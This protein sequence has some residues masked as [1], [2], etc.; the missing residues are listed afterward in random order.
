MTLHTI[1]KGSI[2][3]QRDLF[4]LN[5][6]ATSYSPLMSAYRHAD[7]GV[8]VGFDT[9]ML[10]GQSIDDQS[11]PVAPAVRIMPASRSAN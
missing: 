5:V 7:S 6:R 1:N 4:D 2:S 3:R 8:R 11:E 9:S 10:T